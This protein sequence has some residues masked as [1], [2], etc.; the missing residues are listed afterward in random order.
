MVIM[1]TIWHQ[2]YDPF[3]STT[4]NTSFEHVF[5]YKAAST[6]FASAAATPHSQAATLTLLFNFWF[7]YVSL[8]CCCCLAFTTLHKTVSCRGCDPASDY[9]S[10]ATIVVVVVMRMKVFYV[11]SFL[12]FLQW[13]LCSSS[14]TV[15]EKWL[16]LWGLS[17]AKADHCRWI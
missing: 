14:S 2:L 11:I 7:F 16:L 17:T 9:Y 10:R 13:S 8:W 12:T 6:P 5:A 1:E 4:L 15:R 3:S